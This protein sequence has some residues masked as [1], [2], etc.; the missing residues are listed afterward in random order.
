M[1]HRWSRRRQSLIGKVNGLI[2]EIICRCFLACT[3]QSMLFYLRVDRWHFV[4]GDSDIWS[5]WKSHRLHEW[6]C[7]VAVESIVNASWVTHIH[8]V[9]TGLHTVG[10]TQTISQEWP[11]KIDT[12][13]NEIAI[14]NVWTYWLQWGKS[15]RCCIVTK[16]WV[17]ASEGA[18][19]WSASIISI[20]FSRS[21]NSLL[22]AFSA[23]WSQPSM[24]STRFT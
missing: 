15:I 14:K 11:Q 24:L 5:T 1:H 22:S 16:G 19:L 21:T 13:V 4:E 18:I 12:T 2:S 6:G 10:D 17:S 9:E 20:I 7:F 8:D 3:F 23:N